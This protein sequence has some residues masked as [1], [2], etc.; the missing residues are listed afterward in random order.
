[1]GSIKEVD[2]YVRGIWMK[3]LILNSICLLGIVL[4]CSCSNTSVSV[5]PR[6]EKT[7]HA[8][9]EKS[10]SHET[11]TE[12]VNTDKMQGGYLRSCKPVWQY[13]QVYDGD[14]YYLVTDGNWNY[15]VMKNKEPIGKFLIPKG[16]IMGT[17]AVEGDKAY[18]II[19]SNDEDELYPTYLAQ[20]DYKK[21]SIKKIDIDF[22]ILDRVYGDDRF[23]YM[24]IQDEKIFFDNR[25]KYPDD[26]YHLNPYKSGQFSMYDIKKEKMTALNIPK[27]M[28]KALP[29]V[30]LVG[31]A[32]WYANEIKGKVA[33]YTYNWKTGEQKK[34]ASSKIDKKAKGNLMIY[35]DEDYIYCSELAIP[36]HGGKAKKVLKDAVVCP[37]YWYG[38]RSGSRFFSSN[39]KY[40]YYLDKNY[41]LK[42]YDKRTG[43]VKGYGKEKYMSVDCTEKGVYVKKYK[44]VMFPGYTGSGWYYDDDIED[45]DVKERTKLRFFKE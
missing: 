27:E 21:S 30:N 11:K 3:K 1:M 43:S 38:N 19:Y 10:K 23:D 4:L 28:Q 20:I 44:K 16:G 33:I 13:S 17:F 40:L 34:A 26:I 41:H 24:Q 2:L 31:N 14:Y 6:S 35:V 39:S 5:A 42:R 15:T 12:N 25:E 45:P 29:H 8:T 37:E 36:R 7:P 9:E 22:T 18:T 32:F